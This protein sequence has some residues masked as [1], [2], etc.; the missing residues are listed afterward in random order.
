MYLC[1]QEFPAATWSRYTD[2]TCKTKDESQMQGVVALGFC[3]AGSWE[4]DSKARQ[5]TCGPTGLERRYWDNADCTGS[6]WLK[7]D[8]TVGASCKEKNYYEDSHVKIDSGCSPSVGASASGSPSVGASASMTAALPF[9]L[10]AVFYLL[11][12]GL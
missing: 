1:S 11:K 12:S 10:A 2:S 5:V 9:Q 4:K 8:A 7:E 6:S 3:R